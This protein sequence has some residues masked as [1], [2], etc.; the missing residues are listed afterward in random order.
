MKPRLLITG[1]S[2]SLG[3]EIIRQAY[4]RWDIWATYWNNPGAIPPELVLS[5]RRRLDLRDRAATEKLVT[6]CLPHAIIHTAGS[7]RSVDFFR[8]IVEGTD[9]LAKAATHLSIRLVNLSS[10]VIFDG[11][12]A[13]YSENSAPSPI[14]EYGRAKARAESIVASS[15][16]DAVS[17]RTSLIYSLT[18]QCHTTEWLFKARN[19]GE[20]ITLFTDEYRNP[21]WVCSLAAACLELTQHAYQGILNVAGIQRVNRWELGAGLFRA[22]GL[23]IPSNI[24]PGP[25][26]DALKQYRPQDC[27]LDTSLARRILTTPLPGLDQV[28]AQPGFSQQSE[29]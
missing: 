9:H 5:Q 13:P 4:D 23:E 10:D 6:D 3:R 21:T 1:G 12:S 18:G 16:A 25:T 11:E 14:H 22:M 15:G 2:S 26:P 29:V 27:T 20:P 19:T 17:V 8:L 24:R 7:N 28:L